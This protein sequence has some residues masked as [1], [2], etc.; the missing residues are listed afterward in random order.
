MNRKSI[1]VFGAG[2]VGNAIYHG[3]SPYYEVKIYDKYKPG[4]NEVGDVVNS[5]RVIFVCVPTPVDL[6]DNSQDLS[7]IYDAVATINQYALIEEKIIVLKSTILPGTT[8]K[9]QEKYPHHRFVFNPEFLTER[10]YIFDFLNQGRIVLGGK[11]KSDDTLLEL[12]DLYRVKFQHTPIFK[13]TFEAAELI[14]Y[15][16]NCF[17]SMKVSYMNELYEICEKMGI[18]FDDVKNGMLGDQRIANSHM[19]VPGFDGYKGFGGKCFPKDL[20]SFVT[21]AKENGH[22]VTMFEATDEVNERVREMK[23]WLEITGATNNKCY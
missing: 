7:Y 12:E 20:K 14:K 18:S 8:R 17:F 2:Y 21:W 5:S 1:S 13:T 6:E 9:L 23:D 16:C 19:Q 22:V 15:A 10:N 11:S 3:F 4:Y